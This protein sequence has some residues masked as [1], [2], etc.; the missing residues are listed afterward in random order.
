[1]NTGNELAYFYIDGE[2][3]SNQEKIRDIPMYFGGCGAFTACDVCVTLAKKER[4]SYLCPFDVRDIDRK[5]YNSFAMQMKPYLHPRISGI[6]KLDIFIDGFRKYLD[7]TDDRNLTLSPFSQ[8]EEEQTAKKIIQKQIN[9]GFP[10]PFLLLNHRDKIFKDYFWHWFLIVGFKSTQTAFY[11]KAATY[12][13]FEW[14][15]FNKLWN[16]GFDK[17]GGMVLIRDMNNKKS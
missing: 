11:I 16:S 10:I 6:D 5:K 9:N 3:G 14:L 13:S 2:F 12:G 7:N 1:M 17:K 15:D 8:N 4:Y